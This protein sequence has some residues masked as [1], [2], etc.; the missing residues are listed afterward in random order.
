[1]SY[2]KCKLPIYAWR[3]GGSAASKVRLSVESINGTA[4]SGLPTSQPASCNVTLECQA[5]A[6]EQAHTFTVQ[7]DGAGGTVYVYVSG[8]TFHYEPPDASWYAMSPN[9]VDANSPATML[10]PSGLRQRDEALK[11]M[12]IPVYVS[13]ST[14]ANGSWGDADT[15]DAY[16]P[17]FIS[18]A[19]S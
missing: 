17:A 13:G 6:G 15:F 19:N 8:P 2:D 12:P 4:F 7:G 11:A 18:G 5:P 14:N 3:S 10:I 16:T 1:M 9:Q